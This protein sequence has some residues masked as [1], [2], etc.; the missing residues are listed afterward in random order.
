VQPNLHKKLRIEFERCEK[1]DEKSASKFVPT[2]SYHKEEEALK[3][4]Q[5]HYSSN[6]K[7][8]FNSKRCVRKESLK[9]REETFVY[10]FYG[11]AGHLD[12]FYF[13]RKRIE[14]RHFEYARNS[15][16]DDFFDLLP[17]SYSRVRPRSYSRDS[18]RTFS[19]GLSCF[20]HGPNH[21]SYG[22]GLQE[23]HFEPRRFIYGPRPRR[24]DSFSRRSGFPAG[25]SY[26][27]FEPRHLDGP[28]FPYRGSHPTRPSG[29]V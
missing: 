10:M 8:S 6:P 15:Y 20:S 16:H 13:R 24:G 25:G 26:T 5:T 7:S 18:S 4:T 22:F 12:E 28:H 11:C 21:R 19:C 23:N 14:M 17:R 1:K 3:P 9:P 27:H 29:E 2:S